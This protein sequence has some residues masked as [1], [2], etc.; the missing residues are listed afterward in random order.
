[1]PVWDVELAHGV[2]RRDIISPDGGCQTGTWQGDKLSSRNCLP[3]KV[4]NRPVNSLELHFVHPHTPVKINGTKG[5]SVVEFA[6]M[7]EYEQ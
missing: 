7:C 4:H 3:E 6:C 1:M 5:E 2:E